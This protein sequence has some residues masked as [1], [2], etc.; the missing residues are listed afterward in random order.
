M[1]TAAEWYY[2]REG[3]RAGPV[4][5]DE[6]RQMLRAG[7]VHRDELVW[8]AGMA[9]WLPASQVDK[10]RES[11]FLNPGQGVPGAGGAQPITSGM[12]APAAAGQ[13]G[14]YGRPGMLNYSMPQMESLVFTPRAMDMLRATKPWVRLISVLIFIASAFLIGIAVLLMTG[15]FAFGGMRAGAGA[16]VVGV[17]YLAISC[18]YLAPAIYLNRYASRIGDLMRM[19]RADILE[20]ALE[21]QKSFWKFVGILALI[22]IILQILGLALMAL[23][24]LMAR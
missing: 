24:A 1:S 14:Q 20:A 9:D 12:T 23:G 15:A 4:T 19:N 11:S 13:P 5:I 18:L 22:G 10:L 16:T 6:L 21:A 2:Q 3:Q 8:G 7:Q 17:V